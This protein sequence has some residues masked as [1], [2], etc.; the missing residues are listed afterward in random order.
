MASR[1]VSFYPHGTQP[2]STLSLSARRRP[3]S[4][5]RQWRL[6]NQVGCLSLLPLKHLQNLGLEAGHQHQDSDW[7]Q[8]LSRQSAVSER[9]KICSWAEPA[10][11]QLCFGLNWRA[12]PS[13]R[14]SRMTAPCRA[15]PTTRI[16]TCFSAGAQT[17]L[18]AWWSSILVA[19]CSG[20]GSTEMQSKCC[21]W[22]PNQIC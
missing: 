10:T 4:G 22:A 15:W 2:G 6:Y 12:S 7:A 16:G 5:E 18:F 13:G 17:A 9:N 21:C 8:L 19:C 20:L 14:L 11:A 1:V 3:T